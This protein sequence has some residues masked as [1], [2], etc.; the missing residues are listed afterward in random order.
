[1]S[2]VAQCPHCETRFNLQSDMGGKSM[3][4]PNFECRQV[5]TVKALEEK[6]PAP[7]PPP[8][9]PKAT[10]APPKTSPPKTASKKSAKPVV[11]EAEVVDAVVAPPKVKEVVW[12][13]GT[14]V[15][16]PVAKK[17]KKPLKP[18]VAE[19]EDLLVR[20]KKKS[21]RRPM[22]LIGMSILVVLLLG[23][24]GFYAVRYE[25]LNE[26]RMV[27]QA[28]KE[29]ADNDY[30]AAAKTYDKLTTE[31]PDSNRM[32]EYK[33]FADLAAM[34]TVVRSVTN[35]DDYEPA[36]TR[37]KTFIGAHKD[38]PFAKPT[39]GFGR[40]VLE[41]GKKLG[42]DIAAHASTRVQAFKGNR[43][44]SD[45]L[46]RADKAIAK[47]RELWP[48]LEPFRGPDDSALDKSRAALDLDQAEKDVKRERARS[49]AITRAKEQLEN[50]TDALIQCA[51]TDLKT[52]G[53]LDDAEA[54]TLIAAAKGK[55]RDLVRYED[56]PAGPQQPPP[57][58]AASLLFV[59]PVGTPKL[60][61]PATADP[62]V[63]LCVARGILY[64]L[65]EDTGALV[66]ATRVGPDVTDPPALTRVE[67]ATGPTD[68]AVVTSNVGNAPAV[69]AHVLKPGA[70]KA[71]AVLWYQPLV[72]PPAG[73]GEEPQ[74]APAAGPAVVVGNRAFVP[75]RDLLGT[76]VEFD[77]ITGN[78]VGCIRLGQPV[79]ERG[80]V[81]RPGTS[82]LYVAADARRLYLIDAGGKDDDGN[83][84]NPRCVQ[85]I[86]TGH[87]AGT[88]RV[89]PLFIGPEGT[90][91][92]E[93]W[94]VLVQADGPAV[95]KLRAFSV[96]AV[97][98]PVAE[99]T[100]VPE[101]L[102]KPVVELPVPGWVW[103]NPA[104]DGERLA[105]ASDT[106]QF[107]LFGVNQV[108]NLDRA[109]FPLATPTLPSPADDRPVRSLV[110]PVEESVYWLLAGGYLQKA[111]LA[112]V[113]NKGQEVVLSG[114]RLNVGEPIQAAQTNARKDTACVVVRSPNSSGCR[115]V[116]FDLRT[117]EVRWQR[118]LGLVP[119]KLSSA[120]QFAA[121]ISQGD[122]F[123]LVDED[124]GIVVVPAASGAGVGQT[125]AAPAGWVIASAPTNATG[126][127]VVT[128]SA[129]GQMVFA[130]TPVTAREGG[131]KFVVRRVAGGKLIGKADE[132]DE[133]NAPGAI[134]G[135][136]AVVGGSLLIPTADGY[137]HRFVPGTAAMVPGPQWRGERA[138]ANAVCSITPLSDSTFATSDGGKKLSRWEWP[139]A[140]NTRFNPAG[141]WE[142]REAVA[143]PGIVVPPAEPGGSPRLVV[144]DVSGSVWLFAADKTG[145]HQ[146]RWK[147]GDR[148]AIPVGRPSSA[149]ASQ[150]A[151][152]TRTLVAYVVNGRAAVAINPD[153]EDPLWAVQT[154]AD[155]SI[156]I[157]GAPQPAGEN[158]WV[159]TDLA[160]RVVLIDGT[161]GEVLATQTA[162]LP[163]AVPTAASGVTA[164]TALTPLSDGSAV[165]IELP[166]KEPPKK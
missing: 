136:P 18:E 166:K 7:E 70:L 128:A 30:V 23:F 147:A 135:Q 132:P 134:A 93:R 117:G 154:S 143:G 24:A 120:E 112:L 162:G 46:Q 36:V 77:L 38:S 1:M 111:R 113:P 48:L 25:S 51:E 50:P 58:A 54:Q 6:G 53:F 33:F 16:P 89:P 101:T 165:V 155:V 43:T 79:A 47:G 94:M 86:A 106:G 87:L 116:A 81:L 142:L 12:S 62:T 140:A 115:A 102:A 72:A 49:V 10:S 26:E 83:R 60:R 125:L 4:C 160:G 107:R 34:Q 57:T 69:A 97:S 145:L 78:R 61:E 64:A 164:N 22:I 121:P 74:A 8:P 29:Y 148:S 159:V 137:V 13:E 15:P 56:Y 108:G 82:L 158:R 109:L 44:K 21:N 66:W 157:V 3:R 14:D 129:D 73:P 133:V 71:G 88:L 91:A 92:A 114:A 96:G 131:A 39:S 127:T 84:V 37:L 153:R 99:G 17:G 141:S 149:F 52:A 27:A 100:T 104:S 65:S 80:A 98:P 11:V 63:F 67:L 75:L 105:V 144:A 32:D 31:Y 123:V 55:L 40:D 146:R 19:E 156:T 139:V 126:P 28:K 119:A 35:R 5:F 150:P 45:E 163:G 42:E 20:R 90:E 85:V 95:T 130:V 76:V 59:T 161:S 2:I 124:G 122:S 152:A 68:I 138:P 41:A 103:F 9:P 151:D 118:Q 110:I